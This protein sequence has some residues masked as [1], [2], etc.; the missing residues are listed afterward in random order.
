MQADF[1]RCVKNGGRVRTQTLSNNRYM[2]I[3]FLGGKSYAG[4]VH[5][6]KSKSK[7]KESSPGREFMKKHSN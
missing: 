4:E 5:K 7:N 3:C 2:K 1:N 6:K